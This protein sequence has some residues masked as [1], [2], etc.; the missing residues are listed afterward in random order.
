[1]MALNQE[2]LGRFAAAFS[3]IDEIERYEIGEFHTSV[4]KNE[5]FFTPFSH[6]DK[7]TAQLYAHRFHAL[8][9]CI[10]EIVGRGW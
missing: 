9:D 5:L 7:T 4:Y 2:K 6:L 10:L 3:L 8:K 1:M